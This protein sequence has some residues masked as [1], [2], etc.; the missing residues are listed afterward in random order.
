MK[1][2]LIVVI[3]LLV[4]AAIVAAVLVLNRRHRTQK[5]QHAVAIRH[6]AGAETR[7]VRESQLHAEE[8]EARAERA[9]A[10]AAQ[11]ERE[12]AD[13]RHGVSAEQAAY[14]DRIREA[15]RIDPEVDHRSQEYAPDTTPV[16]GPGDER[17]DVR[18][19]QTEG[20]RTP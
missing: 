8:A 4:L 2:V 5:H 10:Q 18:P 11:A 15:D 14:E 7:G 16:D 19:E 6:E 20:R 9:R 3:A 12:A 1:T 17:R 13:A